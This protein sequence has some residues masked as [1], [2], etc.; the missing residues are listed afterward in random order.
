M[1]NCVDAAVDAMKAPSRN[2]ALDRVGREARRQELSKSD[3]AVLAG[4]DP[5]DEPIGFA[6]AAFLAHS[7]IR[8]QRPGFSPWR[9][10][11]R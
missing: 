6:V 10:R 2:T 8:R 1:A 5:G 11:W 9:R 4:D 7:A 3:H